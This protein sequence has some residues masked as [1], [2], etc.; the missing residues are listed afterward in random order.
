[1]KAI[2]TMKFKVILCSLVFS[3]LTAC[4]GSSDSNG[5]E[6]KNTTQNSSQEKNAD[7]IETDSSRDDT[8]PSILTGFLGSQAIDGQN[9]KISI[10]DAT[11][12]GELS[13][14]NATIVEINSLEVTGKLT[15][16]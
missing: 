16:N 2:H 14:T 3:M 11:V 5:E 4:G 1:M 13:I 15:I 7:D 8:D 6:E 10:E 12:E 9:K